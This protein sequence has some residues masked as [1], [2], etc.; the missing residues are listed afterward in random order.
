MFFE[1]SNY[2]KYHDLNKTIQMNMVL[3]TLSTEGVLYVFF[4]PTLPPLL[5]E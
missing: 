3:N 2:I 4:L 1:V 5:S